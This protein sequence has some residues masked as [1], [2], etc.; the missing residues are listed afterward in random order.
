MVVFV[1]R[2]DINHW[3]INLWGMIRTYVFTLINLTNREE[4]LREIHKKTI[5]A[6]LRQYKLTNGREP[7]NNKVGLKQ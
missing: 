5:I 3:D 6:L 2:N 1:I 4:P 7:K